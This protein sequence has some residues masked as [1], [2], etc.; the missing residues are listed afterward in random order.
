MMTGSIHGRFQPFHNGHLGYLKAALEHTEN[1]YIGLTRVLTEP[2]IG[3]DVAPH[4]LCSESNPFTYFERC[5]I[6]EAV[7]AHE[8][9]DP[10]RIRIGPFPIEDPER[11]VEF[12]PLTAP[13]FTT[14]V[15]GWNVRKVEVLETLGYKVEVVDVPKSELVRS[16]TSIR[17]AMRQD[18]PIWRS[19]VPEGA[20]SL[21][22]EFIDRGV[23]GA[24]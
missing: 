21:L 15:D 4:R 6:I 5:Q 11:L 23:L 1:V 22:D 13:C 12:W 8:N 19:W 9:I 20:L 18:D 24:R 7:I 17:A 2:G 10:G 14:L 16:G 3:G